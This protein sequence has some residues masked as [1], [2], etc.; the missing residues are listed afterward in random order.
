LLRCRALLDAGLS[1]DVLREIGRAV[2]CNITVEPEGTGRD[3]QAGVRAQYQFGEPAAA[4]AEDEGLAQ[5]AV[6]VV[7]RART[8]SAQYANEHADPRGCAKD[9]LLLFTV[10][11]PPGVRNRDGVAPWGEK[12]PITSRSMCRSGS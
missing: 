11:C 8:A 3:S 9:P 12:T 7:R 2:V 6:G 4:A 5:A 10:R 1:Y